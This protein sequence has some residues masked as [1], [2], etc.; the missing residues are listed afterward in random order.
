MKICNKCKIEKLLCEFYND[1][2]RK[3]G[4]SYIC[5]SCFNLSKKSYR[6]NN[7]DKI[8]ENG[9]YYHKKNKDSINK[10]KALYYERNKDKIK[11]KGRKYREN[12]KE[13]IKAQQLAYSETHKEEIKKYLTMY[14]SKLE[15][16]ARRNDYYRK[17]RKTDQKFALICMMRDNTKRVFDS[18]GIKKNASTEE[19]F[20]CT[21]EQLKIYIES[22]FTS[23]MTWENRGLKGWCLDHIK[24]IS[25][26]DLNNQEEIKKCCYYTNLQPLWT[27]TEI[28]MIYGEDSSYIGNVEKKNRLIKGGRQNT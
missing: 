24:P 11:I 20:G 13:K 9:A 26:F 12:N 23:G 15:V 25:S 16:K 10:K 1:K 22:Q 18:V 14:H 17:R 21:R 28:A 5:K 27:T 3:D 6:E 19:L 4:L 8:S 2:S 7:K